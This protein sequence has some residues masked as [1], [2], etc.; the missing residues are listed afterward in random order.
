MS[1]NANARM[2]AGRGAGRGRQRLPQ[3]KAF[4]SKHEDDAMKA[5]TF[6]MG[7]TADAANFVKTIETYTTFVGR[8]G[9]E[10]SN[11][12]KQILKGEVDVLPTIP[13]PARPT[14]QEIAADDLE[15]SIY[16]E[17]RKTALRKQDK[18]A[19]VI[20]QLYDEIWEQCS[21][22]LKAKLKGE[23]GFEAVGTTRDPLQLRSRIQRVCCGFEAHRMKYYAVA[24]AI[25]KLLLFY[26]KNGMSNEDYYEQFLALWDIVV[27]FGGSINN[28]TTLIDTR[29]AEIAI[30]NNHLNANGAGDPNGNDM[31]SAT[32]E[33]DETM[34]ACYMLSGANNVKFSALKD[35]LE[36]QYTMGSNQYPGTCEK[37]LG[38]MD[39]FRAPLSAQPTYRGSQPGRTGEDDGLVFVQEGEEDEDAGVDEGANMAQRG[40]YQMR[41]KADI[42]TPEYKARYGDKTCYHCNKL[43]HIATDCP[44]LDQKKMA[45]IYSQFGYSALQGNIVKKNFL[46]LDTCTTDDYVPNRAYLTR[47]RTSAKG[48]RLQ[49]NAG[50]TVIHKRGFLGSLKVWHGENEGANVMSLRTLEELCRKKGGKLSYDSEKSEGGFVA[51]FGNNK[52]VTFKRCPESDF[53][54]IDLDE[55]FED[56]AVMLLQSVHENM[57]GYT[58]QEVQRAINT[59]DT[60]AE[61]AYVSD[62][63]LKTELSRP[64]L[65]SSGITRADISHAN[66]IFGPRAHQIIRGKEKRKKP[67]RVEPEYCSV[68]QTI[69]DKYKYVT[70]VGDVMFVCGLPFFISM[71]R[72][73][74]FVTAQYRPRRTAKLLKNALKETVDL[75]KRAGFTVQTCLMDNE[76][77]PL[78]KLMGDTCVINTTAKNEHVGEIERLI[79]TVKGKGR[80][81]VSEIRDLGVTHLPFAVVKALITFVV[82]WQNALLSKN[83]ISQELSP[84][85]IVLRWQ[86]DCKKHMKARFGAYCEVS[87]DSDITNTQDDRSTPSMCLGP[88]GNFQGT[89]KF[90]NL[91]TGD[92]IKR[93][94]FTVLPYPNRMIK[95]INEWGAKNKLEAK[96]TFH[97][98]NNKPFSWEDDAADE[99]NLVAD[100]AV[101][102]EAAPFPDIPAE[103]PGVRLQEDM[104][105]TA[106]E[107]VPVPSDHDL[108]DVAAAN[109][110]FGSQDNNVPGVQ[111]E[112]DEVQPPQEQ[113]YN[114]I[115]DAP[116]AVPAAEGEYDGSADDSAA[117]TA[118]PEWENPHDQDQANGAEDTSIQDQD[119][120]TSIQDQDQDTS[121]QDL[122]PA[123]DANNN[124]DDGVAQRT[125]RRRRQRYDDVHVSTSRSRRSRR[126]TP[127]TGMN[128]LSAKTTNNVK[129]AFDKESETEEAK[130]L[131][132]GR[133][134]IKRK[135]NR[136][137]VRKF[138]PKDGR[139]RAPPKRKKFTS[140]SRSRRWIRKL[141][142]KAEPWG[143]PTK[144]VDMSSLEIEDAEVFGVILAQLS[145]KQ[146]IKEF[147][148]E[149]ADES[150]M[151]EFQ[152][153][154][155]QKCWVPRDPSTL[156]RDE[157]IQALSTVV[158]MKEKRDG[159]IKTRSCV[160]GAPQREYIKKEDAASPTVHTDSVFITGVINAHENRDIMTFDIPGAFVTTKTDEYVIM[161]LR[162]HLCEVMTRIDP[163]LYRKHITKDKKGNP[164]LYVQLYKSLY[165]LLRSALL[166]Y[167]KFKSELEAYGFEMNPYDPCVFNR[168]TKKGDQHTVI[169]HVDDGLSS[170]KDPYENTLLLLYLNEIYGD[171]I[172]FTRGQKFDYLGMDMDYTEKGVLG[173]SMI[174]YI[175]SIIKD[176][177]ELIEKVS[178]TPAADYL[179]KVREEDARPLGEDQAMAFHRTVAQLLFLCMR[180]RRDIQTAVAFLTTRVKHPDEDDW[181]KVKRVLQYLKGTRGMKLKL[182]IDN[183]QCTKWLVDASHG[184]HWDCKGHTGAAMTLGDGA[185][186]SFSHK[187][188]QNA[189]SSTEDELYG[190]SNAI[191]KILWSLNFIRSQGYDV[192]HALL[193]QDNKSA[194]L[195]EVNGKLSSSKRTKHIKMK[196]FFIKDQVEQGEVKIE[197]LGTKSMWVDILTKPKQGSAFRT[198]RAKLMNCPVDWQEPGI[199]CSRPTVL[200]DISNDK[201]N[202]S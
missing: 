153:L 106:L 126:I 91:L 184:V 58:K 18:L 68:P 82:M 20:M 141:A 6:D 137:R 92:V 174:P 198:D 118:Q 104:P 29:A 161:C 36:N 79:Q 64:L 154:H 189:K 74:R 145:L 41:P 157:R 95:K 63:D 96:L 179:F 202:A 125:R 54:Y 127:R 65:G 130:A 5:A 11:Q 183:M 128:M 119:Q 35:W 71:S 32:T 17:D 142:K 90:F 8:S 147:G 111:P 52:I 171:G 191:T 70:L 140:R 139:T 69:V 39:N 55:H 162:G 102:T 175:D 195:L 1:A 15:R 133:S 173:V 199:T 21:L 85:E 108:A 99:L 48:L 178:P 38:M 40:G 44:G 116:H 201:G 24:Q 60:Q 62:A 169:F 77:E 26:Q 42:T 113:V 56:G 163:K 172:T 152:M 101:E 7:K 87:D 49:T 112:P 100:N 97:D 200:K 16:L 46:Y 187:H 66:K 83:G 9:R 158:F 103:M 98:R 12:L 33:V 109:A 120:D 156:T 155:D 25:K 105:V 166:F 159:R 73:I 76:F 10:Y 134:A 47:V 94:N 148:Q 57:E 124:S 131:A 27:Q 19:D 13:M 93:R 194:I 75:Y 135:I 28:H 132:S 84:R 114:L 31:A 2:A 80:C 197:H 121:L 59:R 78:K 122:D 138:T 143:D 151:K 89:Y 170:C 51:D 150:I 182:S 43:G 176:F 129:L 149:K 181:G 186:V 188:K 61:M 115:F 72:G 3:R 196:Y 190:V 110:N 107:S 53:P 14:A 88:T 177:P 193:Y 50:S 180:A 37:L 67:S 34:K 185:I 167:K 117:S 123:E 45:A 22:E 165:G 23:E 86:L 168:I 164:I 146:G 192:K 160:N 144:E 30:L 4:L 136:R 81:I